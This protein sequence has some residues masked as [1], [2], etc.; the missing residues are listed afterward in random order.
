[1]EPA[2]SL[3]PFQQKHLAIQSCT[4][5]QLA[6]ERAAG[7]DVYWPPKRWRRALVC[8][9]VVA[10]HPNGV[11]AGSC[12]VAGHP[13]GVVACSC[14]AADTYAPAWLQHLATTPTASCGTPRRLL[15]H[16]QQPP[17]QALQ[18]HSARCP[19]RAGPRDARCGVRGACTP[20]THKRAPRRP[21]SSRIS[22]GSQA[23]AGAARKREVLNGPAG[24]LKGHPLQPI[25]CAPARTSQVL[26]ADGVPLADGESTVVDMYCALNVGPLRCGRHESPPRAGRDL[27]LRKLA[28]VHRRYHACC[29]PPLRVWMRHVWARHV[30]TRQFPTAAD[31][32]L[33][34]VAPPT[35][36][37]AATQ[38]TPKNLPVFKCSRV[39]DPRH[40]L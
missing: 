28:C 25:G 8:S 37:F 16:P 38:T 30:Y 21:T 2:M 17:R 18:L 34:A 3:H 9:C 35:S 27:L 13:N 29:G 33:L 36:V 12:V 24:Q 1:M 22:G 7:V 26:R 6:C 32:P 11:V 39:L 14:V 23:P 15:W 19:L 4:H 20:R 10:G 40:V 31:A 5:A